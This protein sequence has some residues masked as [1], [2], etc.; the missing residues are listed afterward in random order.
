MKVEN[1]PGYKLSLHLS[2]DLSQLFRRGGS[3]LHVTLPTIPFL[4]LKILDEP[5]SGKYQVLTILT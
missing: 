1:H 4:A 2:Q 5:L 3:S